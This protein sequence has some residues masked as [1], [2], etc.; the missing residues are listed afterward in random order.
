VVL[1]AGLGVM[2]SNGAFV[3]PAG[4][5]AGGIPQKTGN[6]SVV[7]ITDWD[8]RTATTTNIG[9]CSGTVVGNGWI[10]TAAHCFYLPQ[11]K[12][13]P[14]AIVDNRTIEVTLNPGV[15]SNLAV[16]KSPVTTTGANASP[17]LDPNYNRAAG[18]DDIA[19]IHTQ[20]AMPSWA[21]AIPLVNP[22]TSLAVGTDVTVTD[23]ERP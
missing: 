11:G 3:Q 21:V 19:L 20:N 13:G 1:I 8:Q 4:A 7:Q 9:K 10:L 17:R 12:N 2:L 22:S 5:L 23:G 6:Y 18:T 16:W 14:E 15:N